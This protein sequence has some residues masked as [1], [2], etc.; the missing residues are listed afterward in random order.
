ML[1]VTKTDGDIRLCDKTCYGC[2]Y[3]ELSDDG[4]TPICLY[5]LFTGKRRP[6]P[7][8]EGCTVRA[9]QLRLGAV[10]EGAYPEY[11]REITARRLGKKG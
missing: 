3:A 11:E 2:H 1:N 8:G 6:C 10:W 7:A 9:S 4:E 5:I